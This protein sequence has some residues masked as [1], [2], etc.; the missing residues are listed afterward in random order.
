M[1]AR[2][3]A[4][5]TAWGPLT[6]NKEPHCRNRPRLEML[7]VARVQHSTLGLRRDVDRNRGWRVDLGIARQEL[8][9]HR[10][11]QKAE[12]SNPCRF[13]AGP[14]QLIIELQSAPQLASSAAA[15]GCYDISG[16]VR[17]SNCYARFAAGTGSI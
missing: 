13:T 15:T 4:T 3:H 8:T 10:E 9:R 17:P 2:V 12:T 14:T 16:V 11:K 7:R 5:Y 1:P 6:V